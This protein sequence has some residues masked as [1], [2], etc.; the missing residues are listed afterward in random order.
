M[1]ICNMSIEAGA[2][3][4]MIAPDD[5]TFAYLKGR[6]FSP[7]TEPGAPG[8][9]SETWDRTNDKSPWDQAVSRWKSLA[10]DPGA[11]FD[12][13]LT[14][15]A[16]GITPTVSWGTSPGMVTGVDSTVPMPDP[17]AS[18]A[19]RKAFDRALEYMALT[20][21]QPIQSDLHRLRLH[22]LLHQRPHRGPARRLRRRARPSRRH[23]RPRHGRPRIAGR[24]S[25]GRIRRP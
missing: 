17:N 2:R 8:L 14:L 23:H 7:S 1:T 4:G 24:Q 9:D 5:T 10:T 15:N 25:A 22:R 18:E 19:D 21:G 6:R 16:A 20:P 12:R 3:A 13:E 11:T